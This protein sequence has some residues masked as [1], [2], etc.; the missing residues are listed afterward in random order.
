MRHL[1]RFSFITRA[2]LAVLLLFVGVVAGTARAAPAPPGTTFPSSATVTYIDSAT[3]LGVRLT[4]AIVNAIVQPLEAEQLVA[5]RTV[6]VPPA[7]SFALVHQLT[8]TGNIPTSYRLTITTIAGDYT[9]TGIAIVQDTNSNGIVDAGEPVLP[10]G[11]VVTL[12]NGATL[13]LLI[14]ATVPGSAVTPQS[15]QIQLTAHGQTQGATASNTDTIIVAGPIIAVS[16]TA[17]TSKPLPGATFSY[18]LNAQNTGALGAN[19]VVVTVNGQAASLVVLRDAIPANTVFATLNSPTVGVQPLYHRLGDPANTYVTA[20][21]ISSGIDGVAWGLPTLPA[22][23]TMSGTVGVSVNGN[24]SGTLANTGYLD[25]LGKGVWTVQASNALTLTLPP[26]APTVTFYTNNTYSTV[27]RQFA[28]ASPLYVQISAAQCNTDPTA[29]LTHPLTL[30]SA[31]TGD[32]ETFTATET[33]P[34]T[35]LFRI[36]P[37]VATADAATHAAT[38]GDALL[39]VADNDKV[40]ATLAGCGVGSLTASVLIDPSGTVFN[41]KS[42]AP[43]AG[44]TVALI[45]VTGTG[46]N[47]HPGGAA[48]VHADDGVTIA[49]NT[50]TTTVTGA[51]R[52]PFVS[53]STY[54]LVVTPPNALSF[55][56][57]LPGA[58]LPTGRNISA[59]GSYGGNFEVTGASGPVTADIPLDPSAAGGLFVEKIASKKVA[60]VGDFVD[61]SVTVINNTGLTLPALVVYDDLPAGFAYIPGSARLSAV[62]LSNPGGGAGPALAF[63]IGTLVPATQALLT[64]RVRIGPAGQSGS[65]INTAQAA[66]GLTKSNV[67]SATVKVEGSALSDKAYV[68]GKVYADCNRNGMDDPGEPG[69]PGVRIYLDNGT[70]VITDVDGKYS[71]Y[72]LTPRTY[73]AKLDTSSL[74][75]NTTLLL[76]DNRNAFDA[77]SQFVD[78]RNGELHKTDFALAECNAGLDKEIATRRHALDAGR[79]EIAAL[80]SSQMAINAVPVTDPRA[81]S[82]SGVVGQRP[83][84]GI[85]DSIGRGQSASDTARALHPAL[86][87]ANETAT[88]PLNDQSNLPSGAGRRP[89]PATPD[90]LAKEVPGLTPQL[91]FLDLIDGGIMSS[92]QTRVRVKGAFGT[93]LKLT[94]NGKPIGLGQVGEQSSLESNGVTAW[95]YVGIEL[96]PG[97]NMLEVS[98]VDPF[99]NARGTRHIHLIA[100]GVLAKIVVGAP[101]K[102]DA[103]VQTPLDVTVELQDEHGVRVFSRTELTLESN[104]GEWQ[105]PDLDPKE[106]GVQVFVE[107][108][109]G[110]FK[111]MPPAIPGKGRLRVSS[112]KVHADVDI[113][114]MPNLRPMIASGI[115]EGVLSLRNLNPGALVPAQ[116]ND[117]FER[118]IQSASRSFDGGNASAAARASLFLKGKILGSNLLTLAYDSDKP[119]DTPLFR[120]IQPDVF[121]PVYGDSAVKGYDAQSTG[122]LYV[123]IDRGTNY[124]VYGDFSTQSDNPARVLTQY[125]RALNGAKTHVEDGRLTVDGFVSDTSSTQ[126]IDEIPANGTSG[127]YRL[128]QI[129]PVANS[130]QVDIITRDRNQPSLVLSDVSLANFT[131]YAVDAFSGQILLKAPVPSLDANLN[132]MYIRAVYETS[133]G[134]PKFWVG[135]VDV[136]EKLTRELTAGGTLIRDTNPITRETIGGTNFLWTPNSQTSVVGELARTQSDLVGTGD[137]HRLELKHTD[138]RVQARMYA[139]RT[140]DTFNNP[141]STY[142]AGAAEYGAKISAAFD[143]NNRLLID[144]IKTST[145]GTSIQSPLSIPLAVPESVPG[146]GSRQG[147]SIALE[148]TLYKNLKLTTGL[149]HAQ[150]NGVATQALTM[151]AVPN[152]FTSVRVRLDA[153]VPMVA[154]ATVFAQYEQAV[155]DGGLKDTTVGTTYQ[156]APQTKLY[157]THQTSNSL[158]GDYGLNSSQQNDTTV[159]GLDTTYMKDGKMFDEYRIGDGIDGREARAAVGLRNLWT[160]APGLGVSTSIQQVHPISGVVTDRATALTAA[161]E[162]TANPDWKGST[163]VEWSKSATSQTWLGSMGAAI[164]LSPDITAL[165]RAIDN[166]QL[167]SGI[168]VGS[169][170]LRQMQLGFAFRPVDNDVWN[171]LSW[172]EHKRTD[173]GT[174]GAGLDIN[175]AANIFSTHVNYQPTAVWVITGRYGVKQAT[176]YASGFT[177]TYTAQILGARSVWDLNA[178]WDAGLQYFI[179]VGGAGLTSRQQA[180]GGEL[181]YLVMKNLWLSVGYN[182]VGFTDRDLASEDYTQRAFYLR[183]RFKFDENL[184]RPR[185]N[186]DALAA[187]TAVMK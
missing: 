152:E 90:P 10:N 62:P 34:N 59:T 115:A 93:Q 187:N 53:P 13:N 174:L 96:N 129:N 73:V 69:I 109:I 51:Y 171:A 178:H 7:G 122:K 16:K 170:T 94:V 89:A 157:A 118:E 58:S 70:Y 35:G 101:A 76:L 77:G 64:Y 24:A 86:D 8:N 48:L 49:S 32:V 5:S 100:P 166:E 127:P 54:K 175:E 167:G 63:G 30:T 57:K 83:T 31:L 88:G 91:D 140:D 42:N 107:D 72:G 126:V 159:V 185:H 128:S 163:R 172:I 130:Q 41:S 143:A 180:I 125:S 161:L 182:I 183:M 121:Y 114:F 97:D 98:M 12:A 134:G 37:S 20:A 87:P 160:L 111:L 11:G 112:G 56:S 168:G 113:A 26:L 40:T 147:E 15:T 141:N 176:D 1:R 3:G 154:K 177:S 179:E 6:T 92:P 99:G 149:R 139:V 142:T 138:A 145:T 158:S 81:L 65:G 17:S 110:H 85:A 55:P 181:G 71:L 38:S 79:T 39:E 28:L 148:H 46:N 135:G 123:R 136:R 104:L 45:D 25:F 105:T 184:F 95:E 119:N 102:T 117:S 61:Y 165:A 9:A 18:T 29:V 106:T 133:D 44:V 162:Y 131:D 151:G 68:F 186:G 23:A 14:T 169:N 66:A 33:A 22:G 82:A 116:S 155:D 146:G 60:A 150:A 103:D 173:N 43:V 36:N 153:P 52:F 124:G 80:A 27:T 84:V 50:F 120:D 4:S 137:A 156:V 19:P 108:G 21:P 164:K 74:P 144:A 47:G 132:P 67:A 78:L 2:A 75:A